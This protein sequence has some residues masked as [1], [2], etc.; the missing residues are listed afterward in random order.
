MNIF[1]YIYIYIYI[2]SKNQKKLDAHRFTDFSCVSGN[3]CACL[4]VGV[5]CRLKILS[6]LVFLLYFV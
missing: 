4:F 5:N 6:I 3:V 2:D 1:I